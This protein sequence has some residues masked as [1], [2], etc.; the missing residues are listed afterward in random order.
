MLLGVAVLL[1]TAAM[2]AFG[3]TSGS[4]PAINTPG[5]QNPGAPVPGENSFTEDQA[6][7]R[8]EEAG[9]TDVTGLKLDD[10]GIWRATAMKDGK[11]V[12]VTLDY[13]GNVTA[14]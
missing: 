6:R 11:S 7:E 3:Q 14:L 9:Y 5:T 10:Q 13:Q 12:T 2:P 1:S 4:T 8:M